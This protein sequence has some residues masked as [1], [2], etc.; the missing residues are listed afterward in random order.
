MPRQF[1]VGGNF[2]M[3]PISR[4][5]KESIIS[6]LNSA[7]LDSTTGAYFLVFARLFAHRDPQRSSL[8]LR[9][10]TSSHSKTQCDRNYRFLHKTATSKIQEHSLVKSGKLAERLS[11]LNLELS[12]ITSPAQLVDAGIPYVILGE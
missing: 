5:Q 7:D 11:W 9:R 3:N 2:K 10:F 6:V 1:F 12:F 4:G 8:R